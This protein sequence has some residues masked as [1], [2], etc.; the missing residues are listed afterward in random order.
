MSNSIRDR[1]S[2]SPGQNKL[3]IFKKHIALAVGLLMA[4]KAGLALPLFASDSVI[5]GSVRVQM[6]SDSLVRLETKGMKGFEDRPT[7]HIVNRDWPGTT[8]TSNLIGAE[9]VCTT[10]DYVEH[11]PK[12]ATSLLNAYIT[13]HSGGLLYRF[14]GK[15]SNSVWF[16]GPSANPAVLAFADTPRLIP[17]PA[18]LIPG[19]SGGSFPQTSGWY[20]NKD[21]PDVY[22]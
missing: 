2:R 13:S 20:S 17:P 11:V 4:G 21:A 7:F 9:I 15:L 22:V 3:S 6:L 1:V 14:D 19:R 12:G 8:Y 10:H 5:T 18:G 16:P